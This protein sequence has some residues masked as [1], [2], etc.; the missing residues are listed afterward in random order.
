M[1]VCIKT[2]LTVHVCVCVCRDWHVFGETGVFS[3]E[4]CM[5]ICMWGKRDVSVS[6]KRK[7]YGGMFV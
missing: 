5:C 3:E 1:F 6:G 4:S 2:G 7:L